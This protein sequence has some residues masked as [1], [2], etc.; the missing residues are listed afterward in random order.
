MTRYCYSA[1]RAL[2]RHHL[3]SPRGL[4][5]TDE[6]TQLTDQVLPFALKAWTDLHNPEQGAVRFEHDHYLKMRALAFPH[7][8]FGYKRSIRS[9]KFSATCTHDE[10]LMYI[11]RGEVSDL[12]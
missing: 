5:T 7:N 12:R 2:A 8:E 6:H 4:N 3:P 10:A 11:T 9:S 1:D